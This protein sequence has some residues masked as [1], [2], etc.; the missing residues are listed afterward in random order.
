VTVEVHPVFP[1]QT[2][3][4]QAVEARFPVP[5]QAAVD[6]ATATL[7]RELESLRAE[8]FA[9]GPGKEVGRL[10]AELADNRSMME[11]AKAD[12]AKLVAERDAGMSRSK[13]GESV[14]QDEPISSIDAQLEKLRLRDGALKRELAAAKDA[15]RLPLRNALRNRVIELQQE[16]PARMEAARRKLAEILDRPEVHEAV[17]EWALA[18]HSLQVNWIKPQERLAVID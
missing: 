2:K 11:S 18:W 15:A 6:H 12:R 3:G 7:T 16:L 10:E 14:P 5:D 8:F 4:H 13:P 1:R 9:T 17:T